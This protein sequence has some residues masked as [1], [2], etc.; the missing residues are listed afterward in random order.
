MLM[1]HEHH[2]KRLAEFDRSDLYRTRRVLC[3]R[4]YSFIPDL[5]TNMGVKVGRTMP[6]D[7]RIDI[8]RMICPHRGA[9]LSTIPHPYGEI[10]CPLHGLVFCSKTGRMKS[11]T[12]PF[13]DIDSF[14][15]GGAP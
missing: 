13:L 9:D 4:E 6:K 10:R 1:Y 11:M 3:R 7:A 5:Q 2:E 8:K 12:K 15:G 14:A